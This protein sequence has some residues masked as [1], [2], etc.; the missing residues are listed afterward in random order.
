[1]SSENRKCKFC[2]TSYNFKL[3]RNGYC[4][5]CYNLIYKTNY[6]F[7]QSKAVEAYK[8]MKHKIIEKHRYNNQKEKKWKSNKATLFTPQ[9]SQSTK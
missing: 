7:D 1:M 5:E 9:S 4:I 2:N 3:F 8:Q 6:V